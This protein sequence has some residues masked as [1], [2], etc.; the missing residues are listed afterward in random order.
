MFKLIAT[1]SISILL[2]FNAQAS[3]E[4]SAIHFIETLGIGNNLKVIS[5]SA[6]R[7]TKTYNMI[8]SKIGPVRAESILKTELTKSTDK[9]QDQWNKNLAHVYLKYFSVD[10]LNSLSKDKQKSPYAKKMVKKLREISSS[11][12]SKSNGLLKTIVTE[13]ITNTYSKSL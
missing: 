12:Q 7:D 5:A 9:Y 1:L 8:V 11:M 13:A 3:P 6:A 2:T 4:N 10:E